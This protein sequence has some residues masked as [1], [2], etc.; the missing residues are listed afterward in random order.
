MVSERCFISPVYSQ[1]R[2]CDLILPMSSFSRLWALE[3]PT[4]QGLCI[5]DLGPIAVVKQVAS[6]KASY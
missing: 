1:E 2:F 3:V 4:H 6:R 5:L